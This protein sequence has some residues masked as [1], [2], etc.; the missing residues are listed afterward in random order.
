M[1]FFDGIDEI[2]ILSQYDDINAINYD[3][4]ECVIIEHISY[5]ND[6]YF[7]NILALN[8]G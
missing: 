4:H 6:L 1:I 8:E 7:A 2:F 3:I 5:E